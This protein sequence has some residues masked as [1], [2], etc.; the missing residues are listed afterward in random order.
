[1]LIILKRDNLVTSMRDKDI[2]EWTI[3]DFILDTNTINL[4]HTI[5]AFDEYQAKILKCRKSMYVPG[6]IHTP[7]AMVTV[8]QYFYPSDLQNVF[9]E[10]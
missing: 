8:L 6:V 5:V 2:S 1:M 3:D 9:L 7:E 10:P 4:A